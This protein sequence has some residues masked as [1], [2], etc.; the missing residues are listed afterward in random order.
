MAVL[1]LEIL[2]WGLG[3][4][5]EPIPPAQRSKYPYFRGAHL[6][7]IGL[8]LSLRFPSIAVAGEGDPEPLAHVTSNYYLALQHARNLAS[9]AENLQLDQSDKLTLEQLANAQL[10]GVMPAIVFGVRADAVSRLRPAPASRMGSI[11]SNPTIE[12]IDPYSAQT[13]RTLLD[14]PTT[15]FPDPNPPHMSA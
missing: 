13:L 7:A 1:N 2:S 10:P 6:G 8:A 11:L 15:L 4:V 14:V 12:M 3:E 5:I 9:G